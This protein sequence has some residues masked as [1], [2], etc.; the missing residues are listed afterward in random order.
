VVPQVEL[1]GRVV[2]SGLYRPDKSMRKAVSPLIWMKLFLQVA[3]IS[4]SKVGIGVREGL[5]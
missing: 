4:V 2:P 1:A 5:P 3:R